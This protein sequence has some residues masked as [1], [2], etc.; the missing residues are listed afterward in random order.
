MICVDFVLQPE[1]KKCECEQLY[2]KG[3]D[4]EEDA[5]CRQS[6][7]DSCSEDAERYQDGSCLDKLQWEDQCSKVCSTLHCLYVAARRPS[8]DELTTFRHYP[9]ETK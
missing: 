6:V 5:D 3:S 2:K 7:Y 9:H 4:R 8:H 1:S